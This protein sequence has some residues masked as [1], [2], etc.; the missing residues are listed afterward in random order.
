VYIPESRRV[1]FLTGTYVQCIFCT[2]WTREHLWETLPRETVPDLA[3][4]GLGLFRGLKSALGIYVLAI[5]V[6]GLVALAYMVVRL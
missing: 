4:D 6:A 5:A 2:H 3:D 1:N